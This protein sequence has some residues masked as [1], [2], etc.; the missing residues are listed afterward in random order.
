[1]SPSD[2]LQEQLDLLERNIAARQAALPFTAADEPKNSPA[3]L[4]NQEAAAPNPKRFKDV[5]ERVRLDSDNPPCPEPRLGAKDLA[6]H[7]GAM[8]VGE[9]HPTALR[10]YRGLHQVAV[11]VARYRGYADAVSSVT[12][13]LPTELLAFELNMNRGTLWKHLKALKAHGLVDQRGHTTTYKGLSRKDGSLWC[14]K[15]HPKQGKT[16]RLSHEEFK[17]PWRD[18]TADIDRGRTAYNYITEQSSQGRKDEVGIDVLVGWALSPGNLNKTPLE[19][20]VQGAPAAGPEIMLDLPHV[21][22]KRGER[23]AMV[24]TAACSVARF[25]GDSSV[26]FYRYLFWQ[27][28]R[29]RDQGQDYFWTVYDMIR[30]AG[31]DQQEGFARRP[32]ALLISRL[33]KSFLWELIRSTPA[34]RVG[35]VPLVA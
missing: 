10:I 3:L 8:L 22:R 30:R 1:M 17:H 27:L 15:L 11:E 21:P 35:E 4:P 29:L 6:D 20:T 32:G 12:F 5:S 24:D 13:H 14:V 7:A 19:M 33:K 18:L 34:V 9:L 25:L 28:L 23:N 2:Q 16:A 26:D 31:T